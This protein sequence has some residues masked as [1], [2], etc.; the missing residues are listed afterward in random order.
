MLKPGISRLQIFGLTLSQLSYRDPPC[1]FHN[2]YEDDDDD[3]DDDDDDG[4]GG[5]GGGGDD[6]NDGND[7]M[8]C[9]QALASA[10]EHGSPVAG[11]SIIRL[12]GP[13]A[14]GSILAKVIGRPLQSVMPYCVDSSHQQ[15]GAKKPGCSGHETWHSKRVLANVLALTAPWPNG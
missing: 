13:T 1:F 7:A 14:A 2:H 12:Y 10:R 8:P 11:H 9:L 5:G 15:L 3:G 4:G 6:D